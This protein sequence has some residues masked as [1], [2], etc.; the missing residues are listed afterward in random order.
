MFKE[1]SKA[2]YLQ[3]ADRVC[4]DILAGT[5]QPGDKLPSVREHAAAVQVNPNTMM[6]AYDYLSGLEIIFNRRGIGYFT[7]GDAVCK[8]RELKMRQLF[9]D[10]IVEVFRQLSLLGVTPE[11]LKEKYQKYLNQ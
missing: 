8:V 2:I 3:I 1:N 4:D 6:R 7:A 9:D 5:L 11:I 10:E